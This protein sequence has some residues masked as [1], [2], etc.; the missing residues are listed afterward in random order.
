MTFRVGINLFDILVVDDEEGIL[1]TT[2]EYLDL[3]GTFR[4]DT[5]TS[6]K[7]GLRL[8]SRKQY[9]V[10][11]SDYQM[12]EMNGIEFLKVLRSSG[13][14]VPFILFA[15]RCDREVAFEA[16]NCGANFLVIKGGE[17]DDTSLAELVMA[18]KAMTE[19]R[20]EEIALKRSLERF[21]RIY[22]ELPVGIE[23]FDKDGVLSDL[24]DAAMVILGISDPND[25]KGL[26]IFRDLELSDEAKRRIRRGESI[27][28]SSTIDLERMKSD[29][30][31]QSTR[32]G[33]IYVE[34]MIT[35]LAGSGSSNDG[36]FMQIREITEKMHEEA[37]LRYQA[38]LM[39]NVRDAII[40]TDGDHIINS[41]NAAAERLYGWRSEEVLGK[42]AK[43]ILRTHR[44]TESKEETFAN[45]EATNS[46]V[47]EVRQ[48]RKD[49]TEVDMEM[50]AIALKNRNDRVTGYVGVFRD[51]AE[52]IRSRNEK[53]RSFS[54]L[55]ATLESTADGI[56]VLDIEGKM[57]IHNDKY[58]EM[59]GIPPEILAHGKEPDM[60]SKMVRQV[61]DPVGFTSVIERLKQQ[62]THISH[63]DVE[64][65]DGRIFER[66]SRPQKLGDNVVGRV[67]SFRD[68]TKRRRAE[69][70]LR[71]SEEMLRSILTYSPDAI[72]LIDMDGTIVECNP[73]AIELTGLT[74]KDEI[75]GHNI[76]EAISPEER[77]CMMENIKELMAAGNANRLEYTLM[78]S[79][80]EPYFAEVTSWAVKD[81]MGEPAL[82][83]SMTKDIT[84]RKKAEEDL[85]KSQERLLAAQRIAHFGYWEYE[86]DTLKLYLSDEVF[87]I[88]GYQPQSFEAT[89]AKFIQHV[90][91]D[92]R[93]LVMG[94]FNETASAIREIDAE[95]RALKADGSE[96]WLY[97]RSKPVLDSY[98]KPKM[99]IGTL[100]DITERK[101]IESNI[102]LSNRKLNLLGAVTRHDVL[103]MLT[104]LMGNIEL[105][106]T[107]ATDERTKKYLNRSKDAALVI[108][109]QM[110]YTRSYEKLGS[111]G[112]DWINVSKVLRF[113]M[114]HLNLNGTKVNMDI[115]DLELF[116]DTMLDKALSNI[117]ENAVRHGEKVKN[118]NIR[119]QEYGCDLLLYIE[120]DGIGIAD[121]EKEMIFRRGYG[122]HTGLGLN[123]TREILGI[124][125]MTIREVGVPGQGARFEINVPSGKFRFRGTEMN[126][127]STEVVERSGKTPGF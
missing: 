79:N 5:A 11:V 36:F 125:G 73:K 126:E 56:L 58:L 52:R 12:A 106:S 64:L 77:E 76:L 88:L 42:S 99:L 27:I 113:N 16:L 6:A 120:D 46:M 21:K 91:P 117:M 61:R 45:L 101:R 9:D 121:A 118:I 48:T 105:A 41:W 97:D 86:L 49:G 104:V 3:S 30:G 116:A 55:K 72:N 4:I 13:D 51:I 25:M 108:Q 93:K 47:A 71:D 111:K 109:K 26:N 34:R 67:W 19:R 80:G 8:I 89:F 65:L 84:D 96:I 123:L 38:Y 28:H 63:D 85:K 114:P 110:E 87:E 94:V 59:W 43:E 35:P 7:E 15:G 23:V 54:L 100:A 103:N 22:G 127:T 24:N 32:S 60:L 69:E 122:K 119:S 115:A 40:A 95:F 33:L 31:V 66:Y 50:T 107:I 1:E 62:N 10:I 81:K 18:V 74:R 124:T 14:H 57:T 39:E 68:V 98:G 92:E 20:M 102:Q 53:E 37:Q 44:T 78:K 2:K 75:I 82:L 83:V 17:E 70:R 112:S 90:H 29:H